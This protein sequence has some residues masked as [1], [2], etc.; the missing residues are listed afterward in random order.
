MILLN[1]FLDRF[2]VGHDKIYRVGRSHKSSVTGRGGRALCVTDS[3]KNEGIYVQSHRVP[4]QG[5]LERLLQRTLHS[6]SKGQE[7]RRTPPAQNRRPMS[8]VRKASRWEGRLGVVQITFPGAAPPINSGN[9]HRGHGQFLSGLRGSLSALR[10]RF[11]SHGHG[12]QG[13]LG[14]EYDRQ[15]VGGLNRQGGGQVRL[16]MRELPSRKALAR[17]TFGKGWT[18]RVADVRAKAL[19]AA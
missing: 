8:I 6:V 14:V 3:R 15:F 9:L 19:G 1:K 11:P 4:K 7:P 18:A 13:F 16:A 2:S 10:L 12:R 5:A 17:L